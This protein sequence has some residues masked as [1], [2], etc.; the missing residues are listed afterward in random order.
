MASVGETVTQI[1]ARAL[2]QGQV[3]AEIHEQAMRTSVRV[4]EK[5]RE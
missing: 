1:L 3:L 4:Q 2:A 5:A